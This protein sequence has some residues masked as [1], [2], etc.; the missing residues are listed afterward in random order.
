[1]P[2]RFRVGF[3]RIWSGVARRLGLDVDLLNSAFAVHELHPCETIFGPPCIALPDQYE[4]VRAGPFGIDIATEIA[5]LQGAPRTIGPTM[6][7]IVG[8]VVVS[9]GIVHGRGR[10]K[11]FNSEIAVRHPTSVWANYE[12]LAIRSSFLG[13]HFFGHWLRDDCATHLIAEQL[14]PIAS[15]PTPQWP[16]C[17]SYLSFFRQDYIELGSAY[18]KQLHL[19]DDITQNSHK[20]QRFRILRERIRVGRTPASMSHIVYLKRGLSGKERQLVNEDEIIS[21]LERRGIAIVQAEALSVPELID[22][23]F[24]AYI[25]ISVEGS[26]LSH[27]LFT[28]RE[29]GG[30]LIIQPPDRFFNSHMDWA[31]VMGMG[32]AVVVGEQR[33]AGFLLPLNDLL[34][35]IDLLDSRLP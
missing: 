25:I 29:N 26:Q 30:V 8:N 7:Y 23:L 1:M 28:L 20:A 4:R 21:N 5:Q 35:T 31:R 18:V 19:F 13:C 2:G 10:R 32:Y 14:G 24:G 12:R 3:E 33:E 27:A 11:F 6:S 34:R 17:S 22:K 15:M 9:K 16:D